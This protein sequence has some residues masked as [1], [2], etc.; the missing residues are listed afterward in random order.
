MIS[1]NIA[2]ADR[3]IYFFVGFTMVMRKAIAKANILGDIFPM[4]IR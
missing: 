4:S 2:I 3:I 1:R